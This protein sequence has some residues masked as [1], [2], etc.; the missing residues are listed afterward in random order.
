MAEVNRILRS[1]NTSSMYATCFYGILNTRTGSL[2]YSN[3][4]HNAPYRISA[5]GKVSTL[6][7]RGGT[8]L[9]LLPW[10]YESGAAQIDPG[11]AVFLFTDG[12]PEANNPKEEEFT[13]GA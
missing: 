12:V 7:A 5:D 6:D 4:G 2:R 9:G 11:D 10:N 3:A 1:D 8:P 13:G